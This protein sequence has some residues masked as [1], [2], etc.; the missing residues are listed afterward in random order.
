MELNQQQVIL[1]DLW[2]AMMKEAQAS[3]TG[4]VGGGDLIG[5]TALGDNQPLRDLLV[6]GL[7]LT[8]AGYKL[9]LREVLKAMGG[10]WA[11]ESFNRK[12][13]WIFP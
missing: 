6:D 8:G 9:F 12:E 10:D 1:V 13:S 2:S 7:H 4:Y 3:T 11:E 5:T